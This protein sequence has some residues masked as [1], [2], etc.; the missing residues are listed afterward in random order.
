MTKPPIPK[1]GRYP[2]RIYVKGCDCASCVERKKFH[3]ENRRLRRKQV[4][5]YRAMMAKEEKR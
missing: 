3:E 1:C 5:E 2:G 4:E